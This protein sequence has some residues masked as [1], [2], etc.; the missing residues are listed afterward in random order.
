V[1]AAID[2]AYDAW[3]RERPLPAASIIHVQFGESLA[4]GEVAK[5]T[6]EQLVAEVERRIRA[7]HALASEGRRTGRFSP[8]CVPDSL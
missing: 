6:D 8:R 5:L 2:G 4:P 3:P 7:C 1:P